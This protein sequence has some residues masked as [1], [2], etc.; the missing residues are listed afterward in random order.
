MGE[1]ICKV[2]LSRSELNWIVMALNHELCAFN[3]DLAAA[4]EGSA[5]RV[6]TELAIENRESLI[7]K[8]TDVQYQYDKLAKAAC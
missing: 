5:L 7:N 1:K 3:A 4:S 6:T 2:P 8:L